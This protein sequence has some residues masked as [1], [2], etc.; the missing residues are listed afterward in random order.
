[1][2]QNQ[3]RKLEERRLKKIEEEAQ[4]KKELEAKRAE[5]LRIK[6][7]KERLEQEERRKKTEAMFQGLAKANEMNSKKV[8]T[9]ANFDEIMAE[10]SSMSTKKAEQ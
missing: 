8:K 3:K 7:E 9:T 10:Q 6:Q 1:M 4:K 2:S 5:E